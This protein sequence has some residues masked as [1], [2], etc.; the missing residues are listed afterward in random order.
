[1]TRNILFT[2]NDSIIDTAIIKTRKHFKLVKLSIKIG[3]IVKTYPITFGDIID[4]IKFA[5]KAIDIY[6]EHAVI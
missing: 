5:A 3:S 6:K 4:A 1:M 2:R